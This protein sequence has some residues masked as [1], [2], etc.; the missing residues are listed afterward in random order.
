MTGDELTQVLKNN[1]DE[2][3][4]LMASGENVWYGRT[5]DEQRISMARY[6]LNLFDELGYDVSVWTASSFAQ[7]MNDF[8]DWR[9]DLSIWRVACMALN[10]DPSRYEEA[11]AGMER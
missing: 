5:T 2:L 6:M 4:G 11:F 3:E 10:V 9:K 7:R 1:D 8:Y